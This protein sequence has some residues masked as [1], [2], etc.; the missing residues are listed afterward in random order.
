MLVTAKD[1]FVQSNLFQELV[2]LKS[3]IK[4]MGQILEQEKL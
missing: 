3:L 1:P 4:S 2:L